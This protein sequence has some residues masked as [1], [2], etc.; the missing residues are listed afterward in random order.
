MIIP[1]SSYWNIGM[2]L[3]VGDVQ[4]D[5]EGLRTMR[6]LGQNL[7]WVIKKLNGM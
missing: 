7:A 3:G 1:G 6:V 5:E 2:G 4:K